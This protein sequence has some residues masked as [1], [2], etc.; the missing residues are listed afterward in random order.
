MNLNGIDYLMQQSAAVAR[1]QARCLWAALV[2]IWQR[3]S[4]QQIFGP[5]RN[6]RVS[7]EK[8]M[9]VRNACHFD[10][11][12]WQSNFYSMKWGQEQHWQGSLTGRKRLRDNRVLNFNKLRESNPLPVSLVTSKCNVNIHPSLPDGAG[13]C[14]LSQLPTLMHTKGFTLKGLQIMVDG[15]KF[16][17][18]TVVRGKMQRTS[19]S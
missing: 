10:T 6:I 3:H 19:V 15:P 7:N 17:L 9:A 1:D 8:H 14:C 18:A 16:C 12:S 4:W 2:N 11:P 5:S 13:D